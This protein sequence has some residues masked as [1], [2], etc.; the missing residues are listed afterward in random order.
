VKKLPIIINNYKQIIE[1]NYIYIDK[2]PTRDGNS[3]DLLFSI[4]TR[5]IWTQASMGV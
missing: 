3:R 2:I 5:E 1:G 4:T